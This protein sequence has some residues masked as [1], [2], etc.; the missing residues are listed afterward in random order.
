[1]KKKSR[2]QKVEMRAMIGKTRSRVRNNIIREHMG[3]KP[4][5]NE[6]DETRLR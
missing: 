1:M 2:I 6:V 5:M 3:V 4:V